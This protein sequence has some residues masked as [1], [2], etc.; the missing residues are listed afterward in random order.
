MT[1]AKAVRKGK[2]SS[3]PRSAVASMVAVA[4]VAAEDID[5]LQCSVCYFPL[6]PPI[7]QVHQNLLCT[8]PCLIRY[9]NCIFVLFL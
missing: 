4:Y 9:I 8:H 6:K 2:G 7:F 3:S 5:T 1:S